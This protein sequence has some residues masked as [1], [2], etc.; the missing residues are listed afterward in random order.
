MCPEE[1]E[2]KGEKPWGKDLWEVAEVTWFFHPGGEKDEGWLYCSLKGGQW[3]LV[4]GQEEVKQSCI[5][6]SSVWTLEKGSLLKGWLVTG[7]GSLGKQSHHQTC[8]IS[9]SIWTMLTV[10]GRSARS[11]ELD[12]IILMCP[13]NLRYSII[14]FYDA[15]NFYSLIKKLYFHKTL[16]LWRNYRNYWAKFHANSIELFSIILI[17][18]HIN[19]TVQYNIAL[20][21]G[22]FSYLHI[23][24]RSHTPFTDQITYLAVVVNQWPS[25]FAFLLSTVGFNWCNIRPFG[26]ILP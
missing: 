13:S 25:M 9:R 16:S 3:W 21:I 17:L 22:L 18:S 19:N 11:P 2:Q 15:L 26:R 23:H 14:W 20:I 7:T 12:L 5:S 4:I 1:G 8:Q 10:L 6:G 24:Y